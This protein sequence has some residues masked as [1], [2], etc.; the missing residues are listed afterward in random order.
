MSRELAKE[1]GKKQGTEQDQQCEQENQKI[2]KNNGMFLRSYITGHTG[3]EFDDFLQRLFAS[4]ISVNPDLCHHQRQ[5]NKMMMKNQQIAETD[6]MIFLFAIP[7]F[8]SQMRLH[9]D[10]HIHLAIAVRM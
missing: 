5:H 4:H 1:G 6:P 7:R 10:V 8:K 9:I 2:I 3:N